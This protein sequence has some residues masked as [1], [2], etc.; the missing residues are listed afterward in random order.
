MK[1]A[2]RVFTLALALV[3]GILP[4]AASAGDTFK[5]DPV[6]STVFFK[7]KH[8]GVGYV[9]GRFNT[10]S[11]TLAFDDANSA[12]SSIAVT[13]NTASVDSGNPGRDKHLKS[14][15]FFNV[16]EFPDVSFKSTAIKKVDDHNYELTGD[17]TLLGVTKPITAK[18]ERI[19]TGSDPRGG[20]RSGI[21]AIFTI[22]RLDFGM[23][24]MPQALGDEVTVTAALE[25]TK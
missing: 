25:G 21:E 10:F 13:V 8:F 16:K 15:D 3:L 24:F 19:G 4:A 11:G 5:V 22:K 2:S 17:L 14:P 1:T 23:K 6:H 18:L 12:D 7:I 9:Y 20:E